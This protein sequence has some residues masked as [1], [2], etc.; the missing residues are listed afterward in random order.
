MFVKDP[1]VAE[2]EVNDEDLEIE[3]DFKARKPTSKLNLAKKGLIRL[4][5]SLNN[6][7]P[8]MK[9]MMKIWRMNTTPKL[10]NLMLNWI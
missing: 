3:H 1:K 5:K 6:A 2:H 10:E 8:D 9:S 4:P 7:G